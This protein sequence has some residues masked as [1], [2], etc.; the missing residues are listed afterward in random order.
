MQYSRQFFPSV[1][2]S[3][4]LA[5][6]LWTKDVSSA[7]ELQPRLFAVLVRQPDRANRYAIDFYPNL[8][9]KSKLVT[10]FSD[11]DPRHYQPGPPGIHFRRDFEVR[12]LQSSPAWTGVRG[13]LAG[14]THY[15]RFLAKKLIP[16]SEWRRSATA[17]HILWS[18]VR[19]VER[20]PTD[21]RRHNSRP[22][23]Q[24]AH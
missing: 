18:A 15:R 23:L 17:N 9:P 22:G 10:D 4:W 24:L 14:D 3:W 7:Q 11:E 2:P 6:K 21:H 16:R 13:S 12:L 8:E 20:N 19:D 1:A 5:E